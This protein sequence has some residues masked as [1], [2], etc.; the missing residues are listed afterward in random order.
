MRLK[1]AAR[2]CQQRS[3][4]M[5]SKTGKKRYQDQKRPA[6]PRPPRQGLHA[7]QDK[8]GPARP[9]RN[10]PKPPPNGFFIW[11]RHA[12]LAALANPERRVATLYATA[13]AAEDLQQAITTLPSTRS[14]DLPPLT[15][16]ER[17]RLD[18]I[19][20]DGEKAVHQGMVA[21]VWPLD[22]PQ[23]EDILASAG[24][25]PLRVILLDQL[26]DPRNIGAIM[27]SA[28]AFG[29]TA[30]IATHRNAPEESG[31]LART[32][33]GA[34]EHVPLVRVVNLARAIEMLQAA[35]ITV[36]GLAGDARMGVQS[37]SQ[38]PRLAIVMG[39][40]GPGLRRLTRDHCDHLVQIEI[41]S[42]ADSLNVSNAAAIA[43]YAAKTGA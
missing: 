32:A 39:A 8:R 42:D 34:L 4:F 19:S 12:V 40:E 5:T 3:H 37:L 14:I 2:V 21:A 16:T 11:G 43:L 26:S 10:A 29:V 36:V 28:R 18:G 7:G 30:M 35:D 27:R 23:L 15:I 22:P 6:R 31:A 13:D 1:K 24:R 38:F 33:T 17:Q 25:T 41:E 9:G 20:A